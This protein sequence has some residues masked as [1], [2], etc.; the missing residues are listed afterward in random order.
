MNIQTTETFNRNG[1]NIIE[2]KKKMKMKNTECFVSRKPY[3]IDKTVIG[4]YAVLRSLL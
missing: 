3:E 4:L 2:K 1:K